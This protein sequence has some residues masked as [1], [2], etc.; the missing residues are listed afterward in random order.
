WHLH[1]MRA[2][3]AALVGELAAAAEHNEA[4][5]AV[6][7]EV[8]AFS[9]TGMYHSFNI[10]LAHLRGTM[11]RETGE[12]A[13]AV[14]RQAPGI[15]LGR[16]FVPLVHALAGDMDLARATFEEFRHMPGAI[17]VGPRWA[18]L[19]AYIGYVAL[20]LDDTETADRVYQELSRL[21]PGYHADGSGTV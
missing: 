9:M 16:V 15:P 21:A 19:V 7:A 11:D 3:R 5:R 6:A 4:A 14:L 13:L 8:G 17:E 10:L 12:A 1:R 18:A 2:T 20:L